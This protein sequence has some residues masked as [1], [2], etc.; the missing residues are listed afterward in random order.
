VLRLNANNLLQQAPTRPIVLGAI[1]LFASVTLATFSHVSA[2]LDR[3]AASKHSSRF[4]RP[5][6]AATSAT[7]RTPVATPPITE[8]TQLPSAMPASLTVPPSTA[9]IRKTEDPARSPGGRSATVPATAANA[10]PSAYTE[11]R[12]E[13]FGH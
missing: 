12:Q 11:Q 13:N 6:G 10:M 4:A 5:I 7:A 8:A 2:Y 3:A 9:P 1:L